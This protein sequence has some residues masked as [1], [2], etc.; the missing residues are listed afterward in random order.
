MRIAFLISLLLLVIPAFAEIRPSQD[1][2]INRRERRLIET[3]S[4]AL[5]TPELDN[6]NSSALA[7]ISVNYTR[8]DIY[9]VGGP[10]A[11]ARKFAE[12]L[13][14]WQRLENVSE[15]IEYVQQENCAVATLN[16]SFS[17]FGAQAGSISINLPSL[18]SA[19]RQAEQVTH[20]A[21]KAN[22]GTVI[23]PGKPADVVSPNNN[24]YWLLNDSTFSPK[25]FT[26][27]VSL[28]PW[29]PTFLVGWFI[30]PPLG[31][32]GGFLVAFLVVRNSNKSRA[33]KRKQFGR[34]AL[35]STFGAIGLHAI[36][37]AFTL[38]NGSMNGIAQLWFG[39]RFTQLA[40]PIIFIG[41]IPVLAST[42][43][44][45]N[46]ERKAI[47]P[48]I[49]PTDPEEIA[50]KERQRRIEAE[51]L[52]EVQLANKAHLKFK[53]PLL[54]FGFLFFSTIFFLPR[55]N[56]LRNFSFVG[57][58]FI[59]A[60]NFIGIR[61][62]NNL[63][64]TSKPELQSLVETVKNELAEVGRKLDIQVPDVQLANSGHFTPMSLTYRSKTIFVGKFFLETFL[65]NER[66]FVYARIL[67]E[68][69]QPTQTNVTVLSAFLIAMSV[70]T[71][72]MISIFLL[73]SDSSLR[74][75]MMIVSF[76]L[77]LIAMPCFAIWSRKRAE[78]QIHLLDQFA[79]QFTGK[80][81]A[82]RA[83]L[84]ENGLNPE[85]DYSEKHDFSDHL[86]RRISYIESLN[87]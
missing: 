7:I 87:D 17:K 12:L 38:F 26:S 15:S 16:V 19:L 44:L 65:Q 81:I 71:P 46:L 59:A 66:K 30:V 37:V 29:M 1:N 34:I 4:K 53:I 62:P 55:E 5:S 73:P 70:Q 50:F 86:I 45:N 8:V 68:S 11:D 69:T 32:F 72:M 67:Q 21:I 82:R 25:R 54:L 60:A 84:C 14:Q 85:L 74:R 10:N 6:L 76:V 47:G 20:I 56:P 83:I 49:E 3:V 42:A 77:I 9:L 39:V 79:T 22:S 80:T 18:V 13:D 40:P 31:I 28:P 61:Q 36:L 78:K 58:L 35:G 52:K 23:D 63:S 48:E 75:P 43:L 27:S 33:Q 41:I 51:A 24:Q 64:L 57:F 2:L